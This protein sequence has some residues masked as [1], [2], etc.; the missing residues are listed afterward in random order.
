ML[1]QW[2]A[3]TRSNLYAARSWTLP[4]KPPTTTLH[5]TLLTRWTWCVVYMT[6]PGVSTRSSSSKVPSRAPLPVRRDAFACR[7][8]VSAADSDV[9][10]RAGSS[11]ELLHAVKNALHTAAA[12]D[13]VDHAAV[14]AFE[15][16]GGEEATRVLTP[17]EVELRRL[18]ERLI[19]YGLQ[20]LCR[21]SSRAD[22][23]API[24]AASDAPP[25]PADGGDEA[26][27]E[28]SAADKC[29]AEEVVEVV[30]D[31]LQVCDV[32]P[33]SDQSLQR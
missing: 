16:E 31:T 19:A 26:Q 24:G 3:Q 11:A 4:T 17:E 22:V 13:V 18:K 33:V 15:Q 9:R 23:A 7:T 10:A 14:A 12:I 28:A 21:L 30:L 5:L 2:S 6:R 20:A 27:A 8:Y 32:G 29:I 25:E 1:C